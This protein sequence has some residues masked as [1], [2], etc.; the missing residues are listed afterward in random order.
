MQWSP[1]LFL[2]APMHA[3]RLPSVLSEPS[4]DRSSA[5]PFGDFRLTPHYPAKSPLDDVLSRVVP[6]AD[7]YVTEKYAFEIM[8]LLNEWGQG[9][10]DA[11]PAL[12][13]VSKFLD[14]SI[15]ATTI[16]PTQEKP[17]RSGS[18]IEVLRRQF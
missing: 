9:L 5:L 1:L 12:A 15:E 10:K 17:L 4:G 3:F 7:E 2:P 16:I 18:G 8:R 11:P 6:G 13:V 14:A